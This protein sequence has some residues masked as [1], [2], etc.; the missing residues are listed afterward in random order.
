MKAEL[1]ADIFN[2][3]KI[4]YEKQGYQAT[5]MIIS[6]LKANLMTFATAGPIAIMFWIVYSVLIPYK[7]MEYSLVNSIILIVLII[8]SMFV[9]ELLHGIGWGIFCKN[10][11]SISF[12]VLWKQ[13]TPYCACSEPLDCSK[14][15]F[16]CLL[17]VLVLGVGLFLVSLTIESK[18]ILYISVLNVLFAGG[19][20]TISL[21][22]FKYRKS[23]IVDHPTKIG[24]VAFYK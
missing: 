8:S 15:L 2:K 11:K 14:Y 3:T 6:V 16:G 4:E 23:I 22:L 24:F 18:L 1:R 19:D 13:M 17:P 5:E 20:T 9:H 7:E 10:K 12:G 21:M